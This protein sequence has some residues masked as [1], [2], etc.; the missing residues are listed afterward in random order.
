[1]LEVRDAVNI[2][3]VAA[4]TVY[5]G[6][7]YLLDPQGGE[8]WRYLPAGDGFDSER[9]GILGGQ[10][11]DGAT[12]LAIDGEV[13]VMDGSVLRHFVQGRE[14]TP[15]LQGIDESPSGATSLTEDI[16]RGV[17]YLADRGNS[18]IIAG[19]RSG[20]FLRQYRH[21]DFINLWGVTTAPDGSALYALTGT[22]I[23]TF[24]LTQ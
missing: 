7:L 12:G 16:L 15:L 9:T 8:V 3:S 19:D 6:N 13:F 14:R 23:A 1:M 21:P 5:L 24:P 22:N 2:R 20:P 4:I 11:L 17:L 10:D 18:R